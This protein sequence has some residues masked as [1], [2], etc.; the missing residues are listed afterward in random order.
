V[1]QVRDAKKHFGGIQALRGV[2]LEAAP[3]QVT[4]LIGPNGSGKSTLFNVV[5]GV[6]PMDDGEV[7]L[8]GRPLDTSRPDRVA[9]QGLIRTFQVPRVATRLTVLENLMLSPKGQLG[10]R[11]GRLFRP[12]AQARIRQERQDLLD[13]CHGVLVILGLTG[14]A[15]DYAATLSGGQLK[16]LSVGMALMANPQVLLLDEPTAGVNPVVIDRLKGIL[17]QLRA[18]GLTILVI[19]HNIDVIAELCSLVHVMDAGL[20]IASGPPEEIQRDRRVIEAYLGVRE[21]R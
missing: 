3:A 5:T 2:T 16:L 4:G 9:E 20:V 1:L 8:D 7:T 21:A 12:A 19:E 18:R 11:L 14:V 13:R 17:A 10:E 6:L 15:N